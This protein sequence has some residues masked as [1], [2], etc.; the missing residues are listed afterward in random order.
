MRT[1]VID[2]S[3]DDLTIGRSHAAGSMGM[4]QAVADFAAVTR[5]SY[6]ATDPSVRDRVQEVREAW[7]EL[8]PGTLAQ[9]AGMAEVYQIPA[10]D[11]LT[12]VLG[13]Y[14]KSGDRAAGRTSDALSDVPSDGCTTVA[15]TGERPLLAKNRDNDPRYLELQTVLRVRPEQG[16]RWLALSTAGAPGVHSSGMN[17]VGL[18]VA[19]THVASSDIGPGLPRF[20]SMMHVL[21]ECRTT[22]AAVDRLL[23]TP[24]MGLGT[25]TIVDEHGQAAVVECGYRTTTVAGGA[26]STSTSMPAP[27]TGSSTGSPAAGVVATNHYTDAVLSSCGL[28][29][30]DGT[31]AVSSLARRAAADRLLSQGQVDVDDVRKLLSSHLDFDGVHGAEGSVC[32]H[33]PTL[34]SET[35]STAIFDPVARHLDLCLGRP[36]SSPFH[37][38]PVVGPAA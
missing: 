13:T 16:Y 37:R 11:L 22:A 26:A 30:E 10:D 9:I 38:I 23:T 33:G 35:I 32:Q 2:A 21:Q 1:P 24:Q 19:D 12:T 14:L 15:L 31:P 8:T 6:P 7:A 5:Q 3:G 20:A 18:A 27:A 29:P 17:E 4:R 25:V 28:G 36:C 34:V